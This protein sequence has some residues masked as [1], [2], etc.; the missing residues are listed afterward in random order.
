MT[1]QLSPKVITALCNKNAAAYIGFPKRAGFVEDWNL[2]GSAKRC[3]RGVEVG[4]QL[5][6]IPGTHYYTTTRR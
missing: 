3:I 6:L 2:K 1:I 4:V 5:R